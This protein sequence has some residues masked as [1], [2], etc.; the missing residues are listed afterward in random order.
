[1]PAVSPRIGIAR[2]V[3]YEGR[4]WAVSERPVPYKKDRW[5][6]VFTSDRVARR[7]QHYPAN[8]FELSDEALAEICAHA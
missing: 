7:V 1:M 4:V 3:V 6:L 5:S 8:W 2:S